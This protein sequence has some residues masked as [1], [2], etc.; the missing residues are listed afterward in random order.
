MSRSSLLR[1]S[2]LIGAPLAATSRLVGG[3]APALSTTASKTEHFDYLVIGGGSG[4]VASARRAAMYGKKVALVER[5]PEWDG[6]GIRVGAGYG[7]T[8]VNI[9]C[10]PKKLMFTAATFIEAA[11]EATGYGVEHAGGKPTLNWERLVE[12]RDAYIERLNGIYA[13]NLDGVGVERVIGTARFIGPRTVEVPQKSG[14]DGGG[15]ARCITAD[16]VLIAVGGAP[17]VPDIPGAELAITSDGFFDLKQ[18][19]KRALILGSGYIGVELAGILNALGTETSMVCRGE[20]VLRKGFDPLITQILNEELTR[21]GVTLRTESEVASLMKG[22]MQSMNSKPAS[23][24]A[25]ATAAQ[26]AAKQSTATRKAHT[27]TDMTSSLRVCVPL[28]YHQEAAP[29]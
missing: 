29:S 28:C 15:E 7:G 2:L 9:G 22:G 1:R 19:P 21:T 13:R 3:N 14:D 6:D 20:G 16:H 27:A 5:G 23:T 8:C 25:Q 26:S 18:Q 24:A 17:D 11:D 10:V 4:G 12:K